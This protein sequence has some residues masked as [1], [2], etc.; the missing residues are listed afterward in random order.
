VLAASIRPGDLA[1]R[2][3]GDE[4]VICLAGAP[5]SVKATAAAVAQRIVD[6]VGM[7]GHGIG[8][9][10]GVAYCT[11]DALGFDVALARADA[12]MYDA[13]RNGKNR[14][15]VGLM[16]APVAGSPTVHR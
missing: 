11:P 2:L 5:D 1:G 14:V 10:V 13:K 8:C 7:I 4:F 6:A 16:P 3:G 15:S 12:A 9:S